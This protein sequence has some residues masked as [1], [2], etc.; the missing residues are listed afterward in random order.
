MTALRPNQEIEEEVPGASALLPPGVTPWQLAG[1][2]LGDV[3]VDSRRPPP[4]QYTEFVAS[5]LRHEDL[6]L[7]L[8][9]ETDRLA[10]AIR[11]AT[12]FRLHS[13]LLIW[14][15]RRLSGSGITRKGWLG[16]VVYV[17]TELLSLRVASLNRYQAT[18]SVSAWLLL[19]AALQ[20]EGI[21]VEASLGLSGDDEGAYRT[22]S[23]HFVL[24]PFPSTVEEG[25]QPMD[26]P[27]S[28]ED[29]EDIAEWF[30]DHP[31][32]ENTYVAAAQAYLQTASD[33][34]TNLDFL[35]ERAEETEKE[36]WGTAR[37]ADMHPLQQFEVAT[38]L[39]SRVLDEE[40]DQ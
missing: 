20:D 15:Y 8:S 3:R 37:I 24:E 11:A 18:T 22:L 17:F 30:L 12:R 10:D 21:V 4:L 38:A 5:A 35:M 2:V 25:L 7:A 19:I 9:R 13:D 27:L 40:R 1:H 6:A 31:E 39:H 16:R 34:L 33:Y 29:V 26:S 32:E 14:T 28:R 23:R 36:H